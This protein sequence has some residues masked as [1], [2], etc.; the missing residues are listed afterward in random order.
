MNESDDEHLE[1]TTLEDK[2]PV[3]FEIYNKKNNELMQA[4][5]K[6][7]KDMRSGLWGIRNAIADART[8]KYYNEKDKRR[9]GKVAK[10]DD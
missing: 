3:V 7:Q 10:K 8:R 5:E 1:S 2:L 4:H 6:L 9:F